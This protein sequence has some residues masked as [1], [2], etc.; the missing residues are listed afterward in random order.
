[1]ET[2]RFE[3]SVMRIVVTVPTLAV[4]YLVIG[5]FLALAN[6]VE[7]VQI[8]GFSSVETLDGYHC[9]GGIVRMCYA[10]YAEVSQ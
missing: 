8:P 3:R 1:M 10:K 5:M 7:S 4:L 6:P 9:E 2:T